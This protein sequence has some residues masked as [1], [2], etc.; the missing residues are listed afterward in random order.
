MNQK[1]KDMSIPS[2]A[3]ALYR[4]GRIKFPPGALQG[5]A[6]SSAFVDLLEERGLPLFS[7]DDAV[8][9]VVFQTSDVARVIEASKRRFLDVGCVV[10]DPGRL[11]IGVEL[12]SEA[13]YALDLAVDAEPGFI[14]TGLP[15]LLG[16][17]A[18]FQEFFERARQGDAV[19][20][21][22]Q[23]QARERLAALRRGEVRPTATPRT[24]FD[25]AAELSKMK[26]DFERKD[27]PAFF[28]EESW[29]NR[30]F[31]QAEDGLI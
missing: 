31:E 17:L 25:R 23:E 30:I 14:N 20:V 21:M 3:D 19:S 28:D 26:I 29:W 18:G 9:G 12:E 8:L 11:R 15:T 2:S 27:P 16:F 10:W 13:V 6:F 5:L 1:G 22:T 24:P 7:K 4:N